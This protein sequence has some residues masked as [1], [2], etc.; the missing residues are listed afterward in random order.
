M[1]K[2]LGDVKPPFLTRYVVLTGWVSKHPLIIQY[3]NLRKVK[4]TPLESSVSSYSGLEIKIC[5]RTYKTFY[6]S[7]SEDFL[8]RE[9]SAKELEQLPKRVDKR[10]QAAKQWL[11]RFEKEGVLPR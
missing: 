11:E 6:V 3:R 5:V 9:W 10:T 8:W 1:T 4:G 2:G 7:H